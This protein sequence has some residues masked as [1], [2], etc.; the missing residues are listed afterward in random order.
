MLTLLRIGVNPAFVIAGEAVTKVAGEALSSLIKGITPRKKSLSIKLNLIINKVIEAVLSQYP[1]KIDQGCIDDIVTIFSIEGCVKLLSSENAE[2]FLTTQLKNIFDIHDVYKMQDED[3]SNIAAQLILTIG[4]NIRHDSEF[5]NIDTNFTVHQLLTCYNKQAELN[6]NSFDQLNRNIESVKREL[7]VW[8]ENI[9]LA[10]VNKMQ[11]ISEE[12]QKKA[13]RYFYKITN[14]SEK[15]SKIVCNDLDVLNNEAVKTA[16]QLIN[17]SDTTIITGMGG[18]GKTTLMFRIATTYASGLYPVFWL[19]PKNSDVV[20]T[21]LSVRSMMQYMDEIARAYQSKAILFIDSPNT[22]LA[23]LELIHKFQEEYKIKIVTA[24]RNNRISML[25]SHES[26]NFEVWNDEAVF[27][28]L[29]SKDTFQFEWIDENRRIIHFIK[30]SWKSEVLQRMIGVLGEYYQADIV[31]LQKITSD[32]PMEISNSSIVELIYYAIVTYNR[33]IARKCIALDWDEWDDTLQAF[34]G[35]GVR[36]NTFAHLAV[37]YLFKIPTSITILEKLLNRSYSEISAFI[38]STYNNNS[39]EPIIF[40]DGKIHLKH[41]MVSDLYFKFNTFSSAELHLKEIIPFMDEETA[42]DFERICLSKRY[43]SGK[44]LM[45]YNIS[46]A[47]LIATIDDSERFK[48]YLENKDRLYSFELAQ[49]WMAQTTGDRNKLHQLAT[50][51]QEKYPIHVRVQHALGTFFYSIGMASE[52]K[53]AYQYALEVEPNNVVILSTLARFYSTFDQNKA[54]QLF[55]NALDIDSNNLSVLNALAKFYSKNDKSDKAIEILMQALNINPEHVPTLYELARLYIKK[56]YLKDKAKGILSHIINITPNNFSALSE[57]INLY[58]EEGEFQ[59][60]ENAICRILDIDQSNIAILSV[61]AHFYVRY[62]KNDK[63]EETFIRAQNIDPSNLKIRYSLA[64]FYLLSERIDK[65]EEVYFDVLQ[66][67]PNHIHTLNELARFYLNSDQ[68]EKAEKI[69]INITSIAPNNIPAFNK[70]FYLYLE[71]NLQEK[72]EEILGI[73]FNIDSD[74]KRFIHGAKERYTKSNKK[75]KEILLRALY[76]SLNVAP[77]KLYIYKSLAHFYLDACQLE[78]VEKILVQIPNNDQG[79]LAIFN[80][81]GRL[82][83]KIGQKTK[84]EGAYLRA[85]NINP[86]NVPIINELGRLYANTKRN[87]K[88]AEETFLN[89]LHIEP[90]SRYVLNSLARFY[91]TSRR[92]E[93]AISINKKGLDLYPTDSIFICALCNIYFKYGDLEKAKQVL[94]PHKSMFKKNKYLNKCWIELQ[95]KLRTANPTTEV[96]NSNEQPPHDYCL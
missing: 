80:K 45:P 33:K 2:E 24:E 14:D 35:S 48:H 41:D 29:T 21:E 75:S 37:L 11:S 43:V 79:K 10:Y 76:I 52:A 59:E 96:M 62:D 27:L 82:Y 34:F 74:V 28:C 15:I 17:R 49:F 19:R 44:E 72:A 3:I 16:M 95:K 12:E 42:V 36:K 88:K 51:L 58:C 90:D 85:L 68:I 93:D 32:I 9:D 6:K 53:K 86:D 56:Y 4:D 47:E 64:R 61:L 89:A 92:Y 65:A 57:L 87:K 60:A 91:Y 54:E 46:C 77:D 83:V 22:D 81:L 25:L 70:L 23:L 8:P 55:L 38:E 26:F 39:G 63:A 5:S 50:Y 40:K 13:Y 78:E 67:Y 94:L 69:L 30:E 18:V 20:H 66:L 73:I 1:Y 84:A 71:E 7:R 31:T